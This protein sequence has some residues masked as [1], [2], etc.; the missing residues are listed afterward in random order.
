MKNVHL[1][2]TD[3]PSRLVGNAKGFCKTTENFIQNDLDFIFA[4]FYNIYITDDSEIK[5]GDW[6]VIK[7]IELNRVS[8]IKC[9]TEN[10]VLIA[11]FKSDYNIKK[12]IILTTD[13]DLINDGIEKIK[14]EDY[15]LLKIELSHTK[16]LLASCEK[17]LEERDRQEQDK[18]KYSE[19]E[20][21][22]IIDTI[23]EKHCTYFEQK[24]KDG[25]KLEWFE[26]F[27]KLKNG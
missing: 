15:A 13:Q 1:I 7:N 11:N 17:A 21:K 12:K 6:I 22:N 3:K 25:V 26:Q 4:K 23:V 2:T 16:T 27:S 18:N 24:I 19:E 10:Q 20:V 8:T 5:E 14:Q 9:E